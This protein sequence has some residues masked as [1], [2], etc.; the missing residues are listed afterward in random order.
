MTDNRAFAK[1][2]VEYFV[3]LSRTAPRTARFA[4]LLAQLDRIEALYGLGD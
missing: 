3:A 4:W 2:W 1:V